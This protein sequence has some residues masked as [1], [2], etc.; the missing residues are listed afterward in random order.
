MSDL[1]TKV[2]AYVKELRETGLFWDKAIPED[3]SA[4]EA[5]E[6]QSLA[7]QCRSHASA[8]EHMLTATESESTT[9]QLNRRR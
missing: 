5:A 9:H 3:Y 1:R 6:F 8:L 2:A 7:V 4:E